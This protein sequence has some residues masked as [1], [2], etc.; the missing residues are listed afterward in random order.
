MDL[1][2]GN[3]AYRQASSQ[4]LETAH[5]WRELAASHDVTLP[6]VALAFTALPA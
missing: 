5:R 4:H 3:F 1:E 6:A 2:R